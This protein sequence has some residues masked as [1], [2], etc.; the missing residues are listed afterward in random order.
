MRNDNA[1]QKLSRPIL[2]I[3]VACIVLMGSLLTAC[4]TQEAP[5]STEPPIPGE[6]IQATAADEA[7]LRELLLQESEMTIT[8]TEDMEVEKQFIVK[9]KKTLTG[10][11]QIRMSLSAEWGQS[12]LVVSD[13]ATLVMDGLV[14]NGNYIADGIHMEENAALT[15]LS[16]TIQCT[17]VY[18][19]QAMGNVNI[20]NV[21][22]EKAEYI[23][24]YVKRGSHVTIEGGH[25]TNTA[26]HD[27]Y[28]DAGATVDI[29][30]NAHFEGCMGDS[31]IN[32]GTA[33]VHN[34]TFS[35]ANSYTFN[36]YGVLN[37]DYT[38]SEA[39]GYVNCSNSRLGVVCTRVN[40]ETNINRLHVTDTVRQAVVTVGGKTVITDSLFERTGYH[41][42]EIQAGDAQITNVTVND[43]G[44]AGLEIYTKGVVLAENFTINGTTGI[45]ISCRGGQFTGSNI[46]IQNTGKYGISCGHSTNGKDAGTA[47]VTDAVI[48]DTGRSGV[49]VYGGA[50]MTLE[51]VQITGAGSRGI[52]IAED[53]TCT[54][55][56]ESLISESAYRGVEARGT[57]TLESGNICKNHV[58][59]SGA[60]VYISEKG[61]FIMNGG[62]IYQNNSGVRGGGICVTEGKVTI[63]GG[64]VYSNRAANNGGGLYAQKGAVVNLNGGSLYS[65][66]SDMSGDGIYIVSENTKV[67][68]RGSFY[69][70]RNDVKVDNTQ[71]VLRI[72]GDKL[73]NHTK[74]NP[75]LLTPNHSAKE[76]TVVASCNSEAAAAAIAAVTKSGDGSYCIVQDGKNLVVA[77]ATADMDMTGADTITVS[78][79]KQLKAAVEGTTSKRNIIIS[80]D[81]VFTERIRLPGGVTIRIQDDGTKRTLTRAKGF[82][83]NM[84]VT[85]YGTGLYLEATQQ[86]NLVLDGTYADPEAILSPLVRTAG[87][88]VM[89]NVTLCNNGVATGTDDVRGALFRQ[90]AGDFRIYDSLLTG[91]S[92][93]SGGAIMLDKGTGYI[94]NSILSNNTSVIGAGAVRA[95]ANTQ[96][97]IVN[98]IFDGNHAG[99]SGGAIVA[100][101]GA[102]VTISDTKFTNNTAKSSGGVIL[103][104]DTGTTVVLK[105]TSDNAV[106]SGNSSDKGGV[107]NVHSKGELTVNG[108]T[109]TGNNANKGAVIYSTSPVTVTETTFEK[110]T[111]KNEGG[112]IYAAAG[113]NIAI[114]KCSFTQNT[115]STG[116]GAVYVEA[117]ATVETENSV[118]EVNTSGTNGNGGAIHTKGTY[119]D[120]NSAYTNNSGKNG[121]AIA[122]LGGGKA[123]LTGTDTNAVFSGNSATAKGGAVFINSGNCIGTVEGYTFAGNMGNGAFYVVTT[124][125]G[126]LKNVTFTGSEE[127]TVN[128]DGT[129][130]IDNVTGAALVQGSNA[131]GT[132]IGQIYIAGFAA[133]NQLTVKPYRYEGGHPV[134]LKAEGVEDSIFTA[135]CAGIHVTKD[136]AGNIWTMETDGT[137]AGKAIATIG[138]QAFSSLEAAVAYANTNGGTGD[139]ADVTIILMESVAISS[140]LD[141]SKNVAIVN[142]A[143]K[144]ITIARASDYVG[145]M[146]YVSAGKLTLGTNDTAETGK[147]IIDGTSAKTIAKRILDNRAGA[148]FVLARNAVLENSNSNQ[149]GAAFVNRGTAHLYGTIRN[150]TCTGAGGAVLN[151]ATANSL[152][153]FEGTY[154]GNRGTRANDCFGGFLRSEGGKVE[155]KGGTFA[156]N[157]ATHRGGALYFAKADDVTIS[158]GTFTNNTSGDGSAIYILAGSNTTIKDVAFT[159]EVVQQI[160]I[161][162]IVTVNN[163]TGVT[164]VQGEAGKI[165]VASITAANQLKLVPYKYEANYVVLEKAENVADSAFAAACAAVSVS[166]DPTTWYVDA[167]GKLQ[168]VAATVGNKNFSDFASALEYANQV[169]DVTITLTSDT[170]L[171]EK[172]VISKNI[173]IVSKTGEEITIS[174]GFE[175][176]DM[177]QVENGATLTLGTKETGKVIVDGASDN[178]IAYRTVMNAGTFVLC[179]NASLVNANSSLNG[180]ALLNSGTA[181]LSGNVTGNK[182]GGGTAGKGGAIYAEAG[183]ITTITAG[184]YSGNQAKQGGAIYCLGTLDVS[185]ATF[186]QNKSNGAEGG[187]IY[188]DA[189]CVAT[190]ENAIFDSNYGTTAGAI[191]V[192]A[193]GEV[194]CE[195]VAFTKNTSPGNGGAIHTKGTYTDHNSSYTENSG[196]NGGAIAVLGGGSAT[197]TGTDTTKALFSGNLATGASNSRGSAIFVNSGSCSVTVTGYTFTGNT[198]GDSAI[199]IVKGGSG[200]VKNVAFTGETAQ[201]ITVAGS[202]EYWNITG[203]TFAGSGTKTEKE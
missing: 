21:S 182:V 198:T 115:G 46:S 44:D 40:A 120:T 128:A 118:F 178:A 138:S 166:P 157:S 153:I 47:A 76:G 177:F 8:V 1:I 12:L 155:I 161:G 185:G 52:Y 197:L 89:R 70:G 74:G 112:V 160:H 87:S 158:G 134:L 105:G 93:N 190:V 189:S 148:T 140:R 171:S 203:A 15:Y 42:V 173:T 82:T 80:G 170:T 124:G 20:Q 16:G 97:E 113:S 130:I 59:E 101:G 68:M 156:D 117:G 196:K 32:Y 116:G 143:G 9:G 66:R 71:T 84:F 163:V 139:T 69:L 107:F 175:T 188:A 172:A 199:Y 86:G 51:S 127:Q 176:D 111:A 106:I 29:I 33:N 79:F 38:G 131:A 45:G 149:W 201:K 27:I 135:A 104:Q 114:E 54:L 152:V 202:L 43:A 22:I 99:S 11:A 193:G 56:G 31:L 146:F 7:A 10:D 77:Y 181:M 41:A 136:A 73:S 169:G 4:R 75:L 126:T 168:G 2:L 26:T 186:S 96:L 151:L 100:V 195:N 108:Y 142:A 19:I 67:T 150:N 191:Y 121:G 78:N 194:N 14:L 6:T 18:S 147:L 119:T 92:C 36:N 13:G 72:T 129:L 49:Y 48:Q 98:S 85:H 91:G 180:A 144:D 64:K 200:V 137:L 122:V 125:T 34:G 187:A 83:D 184:V 55:S 23:G 162:G 63:N 132:S 167:S 145:D 179:D 159:G 5:N 37:I 95:A 154:T 50:S 53:S 109:I 110:N 62:A 81:I 65:N 3:A 165:R 30:G 57:F 39:E 60:G 58:P 90:L 183:S 94:E 192:V 133:S 164:L 174:R 61:K 17:D 28:V 103:V 141:I 25:L 24:I 123:T 102:K 35:G 88:T